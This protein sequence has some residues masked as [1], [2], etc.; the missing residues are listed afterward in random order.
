MKNNKKDNGKLVIINED[1]FANDKTGKV[2]TRAEIDRIFD[3]MIK[4]RKINK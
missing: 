1:L 4:A 2:Y 3:E